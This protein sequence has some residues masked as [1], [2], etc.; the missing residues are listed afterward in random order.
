MTTI[1][2]RSIHFWNPKDRDQNMSYRDYISK[3]KIYPQEAIARKAEGTVYLMYDL[4][5]NN[6]YGNIKPNNEGMRNYYIKAGL[7][8]DLSEIT[9]DPDLIKEAI[10]LVKERLGK[11]I[12]NFDTLNR[13]GIGSCSIDFVLPQSDKK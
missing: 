8:K 5:K 2:S 7:T 4:D 10:R 3:N 9:D 6:H 13:K 11:Y 12:E 1:E